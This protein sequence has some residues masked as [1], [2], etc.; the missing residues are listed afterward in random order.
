MTETDPGAGPPQFAV[1]VTF[2][3]APGRMEP[4][5]AALMPN[6]RAS[7]AEEP[8]CSRFDVWT[9]PARPDEVYLYEI[10]DD[11]EAFEAHKRTAHFAAFEAAISGMVAGKDVRTYGRLHP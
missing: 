7:V 6:A 1:V 5:L 4:F 2:R 11:A 9:D 3:V 10:Y 8:G